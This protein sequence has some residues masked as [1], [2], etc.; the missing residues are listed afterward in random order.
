MEEIERISSRKGAL[1]E[2][3]KI[4]RMWE[5]DK[6]MRRRVLS[7]FLIVMIIATICIV[8][9]PV[10]VSA[11][12]VLYIKGERYAEKC[13]TEDNKTEAAECWVYK[14]TIINAGPE[15]S[16]SFNC[17]E[18]D[19]PKQSHWIDWDSVGSPANWDC[20]KD[21]TGNPRWEG[22]RVSLGVGGTLNNFIIKTHCWSQDEGGASAIPTE[23]IQSYFILKGWEGD[24]QV[25]IGMGEVLATKV[26]PKVKDNGTGYDPKY[27]ASHSFDKDHTTF[28]R[29]T[30]NANTNWIILDLVVVRRTRAIKVYASNSSVYAS[31][32]KIE[33]AVGADDEGFIDQVIG[34]V[35]IPPVIN[36]EIVKVDLGK[37]I[38]KRY[39]KISIVSKWVGPETEGNATGAEFAEI[40]F[41]TYGEPAIITPFGGT[42]E[43]VDKFEILT[44]SIISAI[45]ILFTLV[46]SII[47]FRFRWRKKQ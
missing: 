33:I 10:N 6:M 28:A 20:S 43:P 29:T 27:P 31:P 8:I 1:I 18:I 39:I 22:D 4:L 23:G 7:M 14:Y 16:D 32:A 40:E 42:E 5:A 47:Y 46:A 24:P 37:F 38:E 11:D 12:A 17:V 13:K 45:V 35:N 30:G 25:T 36:E 15:G 41:P 3:P 21:G 34:V 19:F 26:T 2:V 9:V 44:P